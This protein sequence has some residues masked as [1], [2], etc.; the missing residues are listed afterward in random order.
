MRGSSLCLLLLFI[1]L[2]KAYAKS[3]KYWC[4]MDNRYYCCPSGKPDFLS[5]HGWHAFF[6]PWFWFGIEEPHVEHPW[7]D[8]MKFKQKKHCPPLRAECPRN[9]EWYKPPEFCESDHECNES[10]KCCYDVCLDHKTC[11]EAE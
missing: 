8:T 7:H 4:R 11:K 1:I 9:Y 2:A 6:F 10:E 3:C 5:E